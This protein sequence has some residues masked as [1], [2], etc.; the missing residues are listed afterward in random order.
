MNFERIRD[1]REEHDFSQAFVA[2]K[3]GVKRGTYAS[4]ECGSD[5]I[6]LNKL[7][8]LAN[9]YSCR[10]DYLLNLTNAKKI[11]TI[12]VFEKSIVGKKLKEIRSLEQL[13][14]RKMVEFLS[15]D[16]TTLS[17]NENGLSF[18]TT[19]TIYEISQKFHY[20]IDWITGRTNQKN[21]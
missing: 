15:I 1:M 21:Y 10:I 12:P 2:D 9:L 7:V 18:P 13:S 11:T 3:I 19:Y 4:W 17:K 5:M 8:L 20:S 6:P 14:L 16:Y